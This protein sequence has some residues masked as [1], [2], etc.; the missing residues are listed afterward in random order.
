MWMG[1]G[2]C[3][4]TKQTLS[5]FVAFVTW[6]LS[7]GENFLIAEQLDGAFDNH[8]A[9]G[10]HMPREIRLPIPSQDSRPLR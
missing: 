2:A 4:A 8:Q 6:S 5:H 10:H 3:L 9:L 1:G 7:S